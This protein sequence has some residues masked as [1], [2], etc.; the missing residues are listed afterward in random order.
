MGKRRALC[1]NNNMK[2]SLLVQLIVATVLAGAAAAG[3]PVH[4]F[5]SDADPAPQGRIW[6]NW[7]LAG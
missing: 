1:W 7:L 2:R 4:P 5:E 3:S 6:M